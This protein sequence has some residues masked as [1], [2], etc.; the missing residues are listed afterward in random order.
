MI[1]KANVTID[2]LKV[3]KKR[4][5]IF[6]EQTGS[7]SSNQYHNFLYIKELMHWI[8]LPLKKSVI[9]AISIESQ[10]Y[11]PQL[12]YINHLAKLKIE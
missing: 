8:N 2:H 9:H 3:L 7:S 5:N 10:Y 4:P 1:A 12:I 11:L 6:F